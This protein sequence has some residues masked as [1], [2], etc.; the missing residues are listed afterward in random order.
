MEKNKKRICKTYRPFFATEQ[1]VSGCPRPPG[2]RS[3]SPLFPPP[4]SGTSLR[5]RWWRR[6]A[7]SPGLPS[8]PSCP[9]CLAHCTGCRYS[10]PGGSRWPAWRVANRCS[11]LRCPWSD[12]APEVFYL[13]SK[14]RTVGAGWP[15]CNTG[16]RR[17]IGRGGTG[18]WGWRWP[19]LD[20]ELQLEFLLFCFK[21]IRR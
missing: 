6:A 4:S 5:A 19:W 18:W 12:R 3:A 7:F 17:P 21:E 13:W 11:W 20:L 14:L 1:S 15:W 10:D 9:A 8:A 16:L 2:P